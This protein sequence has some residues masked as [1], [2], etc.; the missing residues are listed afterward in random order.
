M[1]KLRLIKN[2][3]NSQLFMIF[4]FSLFSCISIFI[5][6][7]FKPQELFICDEYKSYLISFFGNDY[8]FIYPL[9]RC[10]DK[11]YFAVLEEYFLLFENAARPYQNRPLWLLPPYFVYQLLNYLEIFTNQY[12]L[13][14][15]SYFVT[16]LIFGVYTLNLLINLMKKYFQLGNF[17]LFSIVMIFY[18][19]PVIQFFIFTPSNGSLSFMVLILNLYFLDKYGESKPKYLAFFL[20]GVLFLLN[21]SFITCLASLF[22]I[23]FKFKFKYFFEITIGTFLFFIPNYLYKYF[24]TY[25]GYEPY[26]INTEM[27]GQF[28][29]LSKYFDE[30]IFFW[31]SKFLLSENNFNLRLTTK[32]DSDG[33]WYCQNIPE[34][35]L[36]FFSDVVN[37][38][39]YLWVPLL[40]VLI[41]LIFYNQKIPSPVNKFIFITSIVSIFFWSLIGWYP[42]LRFSLFSF[43]NMIILYLIYVFINLNNL[44]IKL[45]ILTSVIFGLLNINHWN[46]D[47]LFNLDSL[48]LIAASLIIFYFYEVI[49]YRNTRS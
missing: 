45:T 38:S 32:W 25:N 17:D 2:L 23:R 13:H 39:R 24:I 27:Y 37:A 6:F 9:N 18:L 40:I 11:V 1:K 15:F 22:L 30:G 19:N 28:I 8:N 16:Q 7:Q 44:K 41:Y 42:P 14:I 3:F 4:L 5:F 21:R 31:L 48:N 34:N 33:E 12:I 20:M 47:V 26:D 36:C 43:G 29:W 35:F 46:N 10:D 49:R